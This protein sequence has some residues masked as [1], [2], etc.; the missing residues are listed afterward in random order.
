MASLEAPTVSS[1]S[2]RR[3]DFTGSRPFSFLRL[4]GVPGNDDNQW[5]QIFAAMPWASMLCAHEGSERNPVLIV[6]SIAFAKFH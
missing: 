5:E 1:C 4:Q 3:N 6:A 2:G